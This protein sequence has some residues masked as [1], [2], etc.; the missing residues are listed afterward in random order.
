M[1]SIPFAI[2]LL[3]SA[4]AGATP[5]V[6]V[7]ARPCQVPSSSATRAAITDPV[8]ARHA[9]ACA[10]ARGELRALIADLR[11][12]PSGAGRDHAL[13]LA[14]AA[15]PSPG[16]AE[17]ERRL[18]AAH[19]ADPEVAAYGLRLGLFFLE[20]ERWTD[21]VAPLEA[22]VAGAPDDPGTRVALAAALLETGQAARVRE[23]VTPIAAHHPSR[24][25]VARARALLRRATDGSRALPAPARR[26]LGE[27]S[28]LLGTDDDAARAL[29]LVHAALAAHPDI[30]AVHAIAALAHARLGNRAE[31]IAALLRAAELEPDAAAHR[32]RLG[33]AYLEMGQTERARDAFRQAVRLDPLGLEAHAAL[34]DI[35]YRQRDWGE[36][37]ARYRTAASLD[38][39][40]PTTLLKLGRALV[41]AE[42]WAEAARLYEG[43][44]ARGAQSYEAYVRLGEI[45]V[46]S[47]LRARDVDEG[48][49][50]ARK[51]RELLRRALE[52]RPQD[53]LVQRLLSDLERTAP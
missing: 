44:L 15:G 17:A 10:R 34:A 30:A 37:A 32:Q 11:R 9:V 50:H 45:H 13:G 40:A 26:I 4:C 24:R 1:R 31:A 25:D 47:R 21:A 12:G 19:R 51:A 53:P 2:A 33:E 36:A 52:V 18:A 7:D 39:G 14:L 41:A 46:H 29:D 42:R 43:L 35:A 6:R 20:D 49:A 3:A 8:Q 22:A 38:G 28:A 16:W 5:I 23:V 27:I 48:E